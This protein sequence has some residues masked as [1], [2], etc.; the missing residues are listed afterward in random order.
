M[1]YIASFVRKNY[2]K[3]F[4]LPEFISVCEMFNANMT[5]DTSYSY[6]ME[7]DPVIE[8]NIPSIENSD[9]AQRICDR[10]VCTK[11]IIKIYSEGESF[12][13]LVS[14]LDME[15]FKEEIESDASYK[16]D[17]DSRGKVIK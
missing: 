3:N 17:V 2:Y 11:N 8:I 6:D 1:K 4:C 16:F 10:A 5:Y 9:I 12:E 7:L 14:N 15:A 13:D